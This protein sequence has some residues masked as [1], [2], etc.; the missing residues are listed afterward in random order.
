MKPVFV[1]AQVHQDIA[2]AVDFYAQED[3]SPVGQRFVDALERTLS[4]ISKLP[5]SG[6]P[7]YAVELSLPG[8]RVMRVPRFPHLV[9]YVELVDHIEVWRVLHGQRD[10]PSDLQ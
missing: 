8:L 6:S 7:R 10:I 4:K 2:E 1:R 9:F 3:S 5:G